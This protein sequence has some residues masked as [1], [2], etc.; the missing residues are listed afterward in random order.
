[1][2]LSQNDLELETVTR[3]A[4]QKKLLIQEDYYSIYGLRVYLGRQY[5]THLFSLQLSSRFSYIAVRHKPNFI[6]SGK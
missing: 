5:R 4:K 1:M 2:H 6:L 3:R